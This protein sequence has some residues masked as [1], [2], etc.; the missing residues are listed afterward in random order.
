VES[1]HHDL[2]LLVRLQRTYH[3][4][5]EAIRERQ[6]PPPEVKELQEENRNRRTELVE[7]EAR[8]SQHSEELLQV[9]KKEEEC[10]LEL[11]HFQRQKGMVTNEREFTAVISEI[12]YATKALSDATTRRQELE[13]AIADIGDEIEVRR[14]ARPAE[15]TTHREVVAE[16]E[17]RKDALRQ[18]VHDLAEQAKQIEADL[19]P[20]HRAR[21]LRLLESKKGTAVAAVAEGT[22]SV[23]HFS[24]RPHLQ[25]RVRR[26]QEIIVC[27]HCHRILFFEEIVD[28]GVPEVTAG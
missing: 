22:C 11:A 9:K 28:Q 14:K 19:N 23:C 21:F 3:L 10:K 5:A 2:V 1:V 13:T 24:V 18:Q 4:I 16:W 27:E 15:E 8:V 6:T 7:M 12:D 26:C 20:K 17:Q 25:Q